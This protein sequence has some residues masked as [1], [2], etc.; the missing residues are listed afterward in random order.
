M[1]IALATTGFNIELIMNLGSALHCINA[2][3]IEEAACQL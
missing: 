2:E 1:R 3:T